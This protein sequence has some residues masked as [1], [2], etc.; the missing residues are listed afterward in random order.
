MTQVIAKIDRNKYKT[1]LLAGEHEW[2]SD[3]PRPDGEDLGPTPYDFLLA[4]LGSCVAMTLRMYADRKGWDL[5]S[6]EVDLDQ[7]RVY[8]ADCGDC[9]SEEG[10]V[11]VIEKKVK[12]S[13]NLTEEQR[14]RLLE[15]SDRCPVN[16]T[17]LREIKI[18][19]SLA[20]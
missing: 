8:F 4:A 7:D 6:V 17:L 14:Q 12:L 20:G 18:R 11:H 3:E 2:I 9:E 16:K 10:Y 13:G 19:S 15:I 5:D 1:I